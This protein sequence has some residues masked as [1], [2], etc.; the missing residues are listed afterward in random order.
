M[1]EQNTSG[2]DGFTSAPSNNGFTSAPAQTG[3]TGYTAPPAQNSGNTGYTAPPPQNSTAGYTPPPAGGYT[4][5]A[6]STL[7]AAD[8]KAATEIAKGLFT[9]PFTT[10]ESKSFGFTEAV[11]LAA[12][13]LIAVV[14]RS[15]IY[16][17]FNILLIPLTVLRYASL[18]AIV[19]AVVILI[20]K[21]VFKSESFEPKT[22]WKELLCAAETALLPFTL[23]LALYLVFYI[24]RVYF[25]SF[26]I[27]VAFFYSM[28]LAVPVIKKV[29]K[30]D[31]D[32]AYIATGVMVALSYFA[33]TMII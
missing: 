17:P 20:G 12:V 21:Y 31:S 25:F 28:M 15:I 29:F 5:P 11:I 27:P 10:I 19:T 3:N 13:Q 7:P 16:S 23:A 32:K 30:F 2:S 22:D 24:L 26:L 8:T 14:L 4:P 1:N 18:F 6:G 9:K 33:Y